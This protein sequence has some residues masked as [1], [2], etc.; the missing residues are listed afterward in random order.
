M[1]AITSLHFWTVIQQRTALVLATVASAMLTAVLASLWIEP[2]YESKVQFYVSEAGDLGTIPQVR[3]FLPGGSDSAMSSHVAMLQSMAIRRRVV[4][5][6]TERK[7][8]ALSD[9]VDVSVSKKTTLQ[10]RVLDR[11]PA[12]AAR[13]ANAF[14]VALERFLTD[15]SAERR[16][17]SQR[18]LTLQREQTLKQSDE[19]R[20]NLAKFLMTQKT[21][22]VQ[23]EQ[24]LVLGRS[25]QLQAELAGQQARAGS[26]D[27]RIKL[28]ANQLRDELA[29][30]VGQ[31]QAVHPVLN[32]LAKELADQ[33]V[34]LAAARA[35]FDGEQGARHPKVRSLQARVQEKTAQLSREVAAI[36]GG[37]APPDML[38][39]QLRRDLL[40]LHRQRVA[41]Q[42][43][44]GSRR[45]EIAELRN[46]FQKDQ[47]PRLEEQRLTQEID[48]LRR[49]ADSLTQRIADLQTLSLR[50]EKSAVILSEAEVAEAPKFP[51]IIWNA[52]IAALLGLV[53][54]IYLALLSGLSGRARAAL[55]T[56]PLAVE[57]T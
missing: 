22:S 53:A 15:V 31:M 40:D 10:V 29:M 57:T 41:A 20:A 27:E 46:G 2:L 38:R 21:P 32:R 12:L 39:E 55:G 56:A 19:A 25:Q 17:A 43:E 11:D 23:R 33:E 54:G 18:A 7:A 3:N 5:Q 6:V 51:S 9:F 16:N 1:S 44:L 28:T 4:E 13:L 45:N 24:D 50:Q 8:G 14:P 48:S 49:Q 35:E 36:G 47:L 26:L 37:A 34:E 52:S 30:P 42:S